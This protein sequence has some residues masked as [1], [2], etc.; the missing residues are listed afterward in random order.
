MS[1]AAILGS[2][3][4]T[5]RGSGAH[6]RTALSLQS[7]LD[8]EGSGGSENRCF[9]VVVFTCKKRVSERVLLRFVVDLGGQ[10]VPTGFQTGSPNDT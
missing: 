9:C 3:L 5:F 10:R 7:Q 1:K 6:V 4:M 8:L 2:F